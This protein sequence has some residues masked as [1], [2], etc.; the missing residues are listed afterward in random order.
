MLCMNVGRWSETFQLFMTIMSKGSKLAIY[1]YWYLSTAASV[2]WFFETDFKRSLNPQQPLSQLTTLIFKIRN[3]VYKSEKAEVN[4]WFSSWL[5][6]NLWSSKILLQ[7][8]K[9][10]IVYLMFSCSSCWFSLM[11]TRSS[12]WAFFASESFFSSFFCISWRSDLRYNLY[13]SIFKMRKYF[14]N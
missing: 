13:N 7:C 2:L 9:N 4:T 8:F 14:E 11:T 12:E 3:S 5:K 10:C 1:V 6:T